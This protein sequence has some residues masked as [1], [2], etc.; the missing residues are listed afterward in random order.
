VEW[1]EREKTR[2]A[3]VLV[4][5]DFDEFVAYYEKAFGVAGQ[6]RLG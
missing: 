1:I 4:V 2:G 3:L 6:M 5:D